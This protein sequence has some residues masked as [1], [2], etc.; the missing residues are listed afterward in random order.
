M[1]SFEKCRSANLTSM[2]HSTSAEDH[3]DRSVVGLDIGGGVGADT[4]RP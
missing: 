3:A 4:K 2:V 1:G